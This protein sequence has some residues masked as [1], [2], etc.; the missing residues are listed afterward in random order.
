[1]SAFIVT[2]DHINGMLLSIRPHYSGDLCSYEWNGEIHHMAGNEREIGQ[3]LVDE[4]FRSVNYRYNEN[5]EPYLYSQYYVGDLSWI[6]VVKL[7]HCYI[8]QTCEHPEWEKSEAFA[9]VDRLLHRAIS[10]VPGYEKAH[11]SI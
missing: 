8:Y 3:K 2:N 7:C 11:W 9:I 1:M 10:R 6:Q 5:D 4:N